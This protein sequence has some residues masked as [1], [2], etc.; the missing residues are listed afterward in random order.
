M[1]THASVRARFCGPR[2][3]GL[4]AAVVNDVVAG[5]RP[6]AALVHGYTFECNQCNNF[7]GE[8]ASTICMR[9]GVTD[10]TN[11]CKHALLTLQ[12]RGRLPTGQASQHL[13]TSLVAR[14]YIEV[15]AALA[16]AQPLSLAAFLDAE[17]AA[18][19][20]LVITNKVSYLLAVAGLRGGKTA[21][22]NCTNVSEIDTAIRSLQWETWLRGGT[23]DITTFGWSQ[24]LRAALHFALDGLLPAELCCNI[25]AMAVAAKPSPA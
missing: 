25:V 9:H 20:D 15:A 21:I 13:I 19:N 23:V 10:V 8:C 5:G 6:I 4:T 7:N 14:N 12:K 11:A 16:R 1:E 17:I 3:I 22:E 2:K 18:K 24:K